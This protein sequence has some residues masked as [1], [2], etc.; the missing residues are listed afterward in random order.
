[1]VRHI[2]PVEP[3]RTA[4]APYN[5]IPLPNKICS[6]VE[7]SEIN[8]ERIKL[9]E[10]HDRYVSGT[11]N[12][13]IDLA[14]TTL[15]PL[16]IRGAKTRNNEMWDERTSRFRPEP[17]TNRDGVPVIPGSSLRGMIRSIVE[18]LSFSKIRS[19]TD[20][21]PFFRTFA[22]G[23][24][25]T[26]YREKMTQGYNK[27]VG[28]FIAKNTRNKWVIIPANEVL[29]IHHSRLGGCGIP[30]PANPNQNYHPSWGFQYKPCWFQ[31]DAENRK[32]IDQIQFSA[33]HGWEEGVLVLTGHVQNKRYEFV[34][35][36]KNTAN[37]VDIPDHIW[38]RFHE[39]EQLT[40]WQ[41]EAFPVGGPM[42]ANRKEKGYM[43]KDEPVFYLVRESEK[44][45]TNPSGLMFFGRAQMFRY[46]YDLS[47]RDLIPE[48]LKNA[49]LDIAEALF[50]IVAKGD[51]KK[52]FAL[53]SRVFFEDAVAEGD[54]PDWFEEVMVPQILASPK[55]TCFQHYLTQDGTRDKEE[56]T[57]YLKG[58]HTTVRG[59]KQ[60]WHRWDHQ[61]N[62]DFVKVRV[63]NYNNLLLA[64]QLPN[65]NDKQHT[66]I[67]PVKGDVLFR[68]RVRFINLS[69]TE[70]GALMS[71]L[72]LPADC[73]HKLGM[74]KPLGLGSIRI[75]ARLNLVDRQVRYNSWANTGSDSYD[76]NSFV[77]AF[78][79]RIIEH[80]KIS[81]EA[82]DDNQDGLQKIGRLQALYHMLN[83]ESKRP[84]S[85][86][87]YMPLSQY[88]RRA[89]LPTPHGVMKQVEPS[90]PIDPPLKGHDL[91]D[92]VEMAHATPVAV[93][94]A[95]L[96]KPVLKGQTRKGRLNLIDGIWKAIF[97][98]DDREAVIVNI[99]KIPHDVVNGSLAEFYIMEQ[100]NQVGIKARF[101]KLL[102]DK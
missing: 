32:K 35:V 95:V 9:W 6:V 19:V 15:T 52:S 61:E 98:G 10:K 89:V 31:R 84:F 82:M 72:E 69:D 43:R 5:F 1:M 42:N 29:R 12:G 56:L 66:V 101:E 2:N 4:K 92:V 102:I 60:Y 36:G 40:Q 100:S 74:G 86:T 63:N 91:D 79:Q 47:P 39:K 13:W 75:N 58:D 27:P 57:T 45:E 93:H 96:Y 8:G 76:A 53:K 64:L 54:N 24:L 11:H 55:V 44:K 48:E 22:T 68:G 49:G 50:G 14:I 83:W 87:A 34:F 28:G 25:G 90:W 37:P 99:A 71:A 73:A 21:R 23:R 59:H 18:I 26:V 85:E 41:K 51:D 67:R 62:L 20:E 88:Q 77:S 80:A 17:Y 7:G 3:E 94:V 38:Q 70:L 78:Q 65:A 97:E 81:G 30:T 33:R 16:F 46:P